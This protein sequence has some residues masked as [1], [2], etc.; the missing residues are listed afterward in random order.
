ML[1]LRSPLKEE[2]YEAKNTDYRTGKPLEPEAG[3][4]C[5]SS[6]DRIEHLLNGGSK[7]L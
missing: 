3:V 5:K 7:L 1:F 2:I 4:I 6:I